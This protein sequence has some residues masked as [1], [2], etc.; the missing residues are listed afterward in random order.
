MAAVLE[1]DIQGGRY[2]RAA[3]MT[4]EEFRDRYFTERVDHLSAKYVEAT[5]T[6]LNQLERFMPLRW[7]DEVDGGAISAFQAWLRNQALRGE[8]RLRA[9]L[10]GG[11]V[12]RFAGEHDGGGARGAYI[13]HATWRAWSAAGEGVSGEGG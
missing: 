2:V 7:V 1:R 5:A 6:A 12:G 9:V 13:Q 3:R 10:R 8:R 11:A 4:W